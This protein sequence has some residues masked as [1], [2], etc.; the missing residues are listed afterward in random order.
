MISFPNLGHRGRLGNQLFQ[1]AFLRTRA[2][3]LGVTF[4]CPRWIGDAVFELEDEEE[5]SVTPHGIVRTYRPPR[6]LPG[7]IEN[8]LLVPDGTEIDGYFQSEK[9][10]E[11]EQVLR[12]Y[13]FKDS[14]IERVREKYAHIDFTR[15]IGL[16]VR[17]TDFVGTY[18]RNFYVPRPTY[19]RKAIAALVG[20]ET[21]IVF[22][23][24]SPEARRRIRPLCPQAIYIEGNLDHEDLYLQTLCGAFI[25]SPST[26]SWWG[27]WLNT[28]AEKRIIVP[29]EGPFRPGTFLQ[30]DDFWPADWIKLRAL[31]PVLDHRLSIQLQARITR[32]RRKL[33]GF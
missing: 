4:H 33:L 22:S 27:A 9:Y 15:S 1:Y 18:F 20:A 6:H 16:H 30:N 24:D 3:A 17:L 5:R 26:F 23:D 12:W 13:R 28:N 7:F 10:F 19:F 14:T 29:R 25:C 11:R 31:H 8:A 32:K 21:V 2:Q